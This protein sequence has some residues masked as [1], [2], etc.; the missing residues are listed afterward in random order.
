MDEKLP[1]SGL[2]QSVLG[3][4]VGWEHPGTVMVDANGS[5]PSGLHQ[6]GLNPVKLGH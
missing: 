4:I 1:V 5:L 6:R 2:T 3:S